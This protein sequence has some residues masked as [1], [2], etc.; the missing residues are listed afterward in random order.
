MPKA[1]HTLPPDEWDF[2]LRMEQLCQDPDRTEHLKELLSTNG[3]RI[4]NL[5][6]TAHYAYEKAIAADNT[7]AVALLLKAGIAYRTDTPWQR[8][9]PF[10]AVVKGRLNIIRLFLDAGVDINCREEN[11]GEFYNTMLA[12]AVIHGQDEAMKLLLERGADPTLIC[13]GGYTALDMVHVERGYD[14]P[15]EQILLSFGTE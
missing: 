8:N 3:K 12:T 11:G 5:S 10:F 6:S 13:D 15:A 7:P 2:C 1:H 4:S 14:T 9:P